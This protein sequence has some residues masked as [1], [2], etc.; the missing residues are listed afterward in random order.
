MFE[1]QRSLNTNFSLN[2]SEALSAP[3]KS[4]PQK[5]AL[6]NL[7][8]R[9]KDHEHK[10][11][12]EAVIMYGND[13]KCVHK[14]VKS[15]SS[16]QARS[17]AQKFLLK[18]KKKLKILPTY[19]PI[20]QSMKLS[21]ESI[22]KLIRE[23]VE[24][25][26]MR[27][28]QIEKEKLVKLVMGFANLLIGNNIPEQCVKRVSMCQDTEKP[29]LIEKVRRSNNH[30][31]I[32]K[33][34]KEVEIKT[35]TI[36]ISNQNDLLKMLFQQQSQETNPN[37]NVINIISINYSN[38]NGEQSVPVLNTVQNMF[39]GNVQNVHNNLKP[40]QLKINTSLTNSLESKKDLSECR[41]NSLTASTIESPE[42]VSFFDDFYEDDSSV[43]FG[44]NPHNEMDEV[45][46]FFSW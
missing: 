37:K 24:N 13:W 19:D 38:K 3:I 42:R 43:S 7:S 2:Y 10:K 39:S 15:R 41:R 26:S 40:A 21:S 31:L 6:H 17:H 30:F 4:A 33:T 29:F 1:D 12:L 46:K 34:K 23:I 11:F 32:E 8:G 20:S 45:E 9:W 5:K 16:T 44:F 28:H 36:Q 18:L 27:S 25:S 35:N 14:Y 22:H